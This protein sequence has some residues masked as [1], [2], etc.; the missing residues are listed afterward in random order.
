MEDED[1]LKRFKPV[2]VAVDKVQEQY[3][4]IAAA[5]HIW[6]E[7]EKDLKEKKLVKKGVKSFSF[8]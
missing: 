6:E 5:I 1:L 2:S 3:C 7:L 8:H 4:A